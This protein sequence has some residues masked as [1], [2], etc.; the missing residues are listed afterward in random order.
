MSFQSLVILLFSE[1]PRACDRVR[2]Y[3]ESMSD[4]EVCGHLTQSEKAPEFH[5]KGTRAHK[6]LVN[7]MGTM[8]GR[9]SLLGLNDL[10]IFC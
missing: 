1:M 4:S 9:T 5:L 3:L 6:A 2:V 7:R 10:Y 8:S